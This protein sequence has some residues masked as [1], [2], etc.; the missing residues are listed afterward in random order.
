MLSGEWRTF[1][2][3]F[4]V[5]IDDDDDDDEMVNTIITIIMIMIIM[6]IKINRMVLLSDLHSL[7]SV[8]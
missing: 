3:G 2:L 8:L 6:I 5:F 1:C 7:E 4:N